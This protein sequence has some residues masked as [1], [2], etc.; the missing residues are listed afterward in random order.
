MTAETHRAGT[1][2]E[3]ADIHKG[4]RITGPGRDRLAKEICRKYESGQTI[5]ALAEE[6]GRSYGFVHRLL[7][8]AGV[9]LRA[10]GGAT[11][12]KSRKTGTQP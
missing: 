8:D 11:R 12:S 9:P 7:A 2:N 6:T 5:R 10:R 4:V 3:G 1:S